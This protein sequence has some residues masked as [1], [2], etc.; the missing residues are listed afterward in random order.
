MSRIAK[1]PRRRYDNKVLPPSDDSY[2]R[3]LKT[4]D[5]KLDRKTGNILRKL[6]RSPDYRPVLQLLRHV[7]R[8]G[9]PK[10]R[11]AVRRLLRALRN[12]LRTRATEI[13]AARLHTPVY[14]KPRRSRKKKTPPV[15]KPH[16][17][18]DAKGPGLTT[19]T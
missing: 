2:R 19:E 3:K 13:A 6:E 14:V 15:T 5:Y 11:P 17:T 7:A 8:Y 12:L 9:P 18:D 1:K 10:N 4:H 16:E